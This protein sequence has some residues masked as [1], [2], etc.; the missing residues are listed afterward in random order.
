[1]VKNKDHQDETHPVLKDYFPNGCYSAMILM[2]LVTLSCHGVMSLILA[3]LNA[4]M[5]VHLIEG[6]EYWLDDGVALMVHRV[7]RHF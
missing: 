5:V 6:E 1:M 3:H 2:A 7:A 4:A